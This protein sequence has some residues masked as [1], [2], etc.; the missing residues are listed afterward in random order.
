MRAY[1]A[2]AAISGPM[3][4]AHPYYSPEDIL[5]NLNQ[6][7][8]TAGAKVEAQHAKAQAEAAAKL[9]GDKVA[10]LGNA[11]WLLTQTPTHKHLFITDLEWLVLPRIAPMDWKS[12]DN[13]WLMDLICPFGGQD[14]A[15][16]ELKEK[17]FKGKTVKTLQP[18]PGGEGMAVVEW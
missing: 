7:A 17:A 5:K 16:K 14:E 6:R 10:V 11:V 18:A 15:M 12:G 1:A 8:A 13:L 2:T 3:H 4:G 9:G